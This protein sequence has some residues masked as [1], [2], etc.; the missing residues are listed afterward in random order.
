MGNMTQNFN[1]AI[2]PPAHRLH[3]GD[4]MPFCPGVAR[5]SQFFSFDAQAGRAAV[6]ILDPSGC[7]PTLAQLTARLLARREEI[8]AFGADLLSLLGFGAGPSAWDQ[9]PGATENLPIILCAPSFFADSGIDGHP[10]WLAVIDRAARIHASWAA[11]PNDLAHDADIALAALSR[12]GREAPGQ[13]HLPAPVLPV[14]GLLSDALC[15]ALIAG[16]ASGDHFDSGVSS[17]TAQGFAVDTVNH[18][19][20]RRRDWLLQPGTDL[21]AAVQTRLHARCIPDMRRAFQHQVHHLDRILVARYSADGG[22]FKRHRDNMAES[23]AF[24]QFALSVNLNTGAFDGG[25]LMFPEYNDHLYIPAI[26]EGIV[27]SSSLLHEATPVTSGERYVLLTFLHDAA[28][29]ERRLATREAQQRA[30]IAALV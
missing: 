20:K 18:G 8:A 23:V 27:F 7:A 9:A 13:C 29:E 19:K 26:G 11:N 24:R 16:F 10:L 25:A 30:A 21:Y 15:T 4:F 12:I 6:L 22:Y 2:T 5:Q 17:Q 3:P 1:P 28:A 14:P